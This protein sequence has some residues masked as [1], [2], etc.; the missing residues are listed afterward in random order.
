MDKTELTEVMSQKI[1]TDIEFDE[2]GVCALQ[3][4]EIIVRIV[5]LEDVSQIVLCG[6]LG[7]LPETDV[8]KLYLFMLEGNHMFSGTNGATIGVNSADRNVTV[9]KIIASDGVNAETFLSETEQF[10]NTCEMWFNVIRDYNGKLADFSK[11]TEKGGSRNDDF[12][13]MKPA[14]PFDVS[15][16][17]V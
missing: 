7:T 1:G 11:E 8:E 12:S 4:D 2:N 15:T 6:E 5:Y 10:V 3:V 17:Q 16:L 9:S 14:D 13:G